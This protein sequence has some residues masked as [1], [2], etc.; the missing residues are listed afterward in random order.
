MFGGSGGLENAF[1]GFCRGECIG[2]FKGV[3]FYGWL[4]LLI[5]G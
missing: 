5:L 2:L 3:T 1:G 4:A